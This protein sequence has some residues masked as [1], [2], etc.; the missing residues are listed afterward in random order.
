[1]AEEK[2]ELVVDGAFSIVQIGMADAAGINLHHHLA[3]TRIG[4]V[5][6][7]NR[8][9]LTLGSCYNRTYLQTH[10]SLQET[11]MRA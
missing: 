2:R 9:R 11:S 8:D 1:M 3:G 5:D 6:K 7:L 4:D 10:W